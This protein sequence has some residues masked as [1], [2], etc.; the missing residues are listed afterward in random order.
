MLAILKPNTRQE[1][2]TGE[3]PLVSVIIPTKNSGITLPMCLSSIKNQ[4]YPNVEIIIV[5]SFSAD[6][7]KRIAE[8][9]AAR[10]IEANAKRSEARNWGAN[11]AVSEFVFFI[12][13]DMKLDLNVVE[14]CV[15]RIKEGYDA[16]IVPEISVGE[17]FWAQ[18]KALEKLCYVGDDLIE[19]TRFL[20]RSV[21]EALG[22]YDPELEAG[23]DWDLLNRIRKAG[24]RIARIRSFIIH[25]E[26]RLSLMDSVRKKHYYARTIDKYIQ[27]YPD[28]AKKQLT[29]LR[30]AF[31]RN[32][33]K[34]VADPPH[35]FGL[36]VMKIC[37]FGVG[38]LALIK[39][40]DEKKG[41][42]LTRVDYTKRHLE[43]RKIYLI[44]HF[45]PSGPHRF[46]DLGCGTGVYLS[47][48]SEKGEVVGLDLSPKLCK[49]SKKLGFD[50]IIGDGMHLPFKNEAFYGIW[51]SEI[52]EHL[53]SLV[54]FEELERVTARRIIATIPNPFSFN[55]RADSSHKLRYTI[56]SLKVYLKTR[57]N[58]RYN[59]VGLGIEWPSAP[60]GMKL[61]RF[62]K[63]LTFCLTFGMPWLAPT[64]C[65]MGYKE[66][67]KI[68]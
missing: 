32:W 63:L 23:E 39:G 3:K 46:L 66:I 67:R 43:D 5:D 61:P 34:I 13:S 19:G 59:I 22:G 12:D 57:R 58:W 20:R 50:I 26:G 44:N 65:I 8:Y 38:W 45:L 31:L 14:E 42:H 55:Y 29:L 36:L 25:D 4:T 64:I 1:Q 51:A 18:S 53:S 33:R 40:K 21:F 7:T 48:L 49:L 28:V 52:L 56:S 35:A 16:I 27:K 37:E 60:K 68:A 15:K 17:G 62:F 10:V 2:K 41:V 11:S 54:V 9:H 6:G 47:H 30:P 24:Y